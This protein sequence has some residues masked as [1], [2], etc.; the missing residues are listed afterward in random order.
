ME[1]T[2][3]IS[4][5]FAIAGALLVAPRTA[6]SYVGYV[7]APLMFIDWRLSVR[8][9]FFLGALALY[10]LLAL[11]VQVIQQ[12]LISPTSA[13]IELALLFPF[14]LFIAGVR[15][16]GDLTQAVFL[17]R[18]LNVSLVIIS[19]VRVLIFHGIPYLTTSPDQWNGLFGLGGA[20]ILTIIG[21]FGITLELLLRE[22]G[23][24]VSRLALIAAI[25]NFLVPSYMIGIAVGILA[26][27]L[28]FA[29]SFRF[30]LASSAHRSLRFFLPIA[31]IVGLAAGLPI[32][33]RL[34]SVNTT[35]TKELGV[36]P[37]VFA[38]IASFE[39]LA[40][41]QILGLGVG[42]FTSTP[43]TWLDPGLTTT[44]AHRPPELP[45]FHMSDAYSDR[46][47]DYTRSGIKNKWTFSSSLNQPVAGWAAL[48]G[49]WGLGILLIIGAFWRRLAGTL[50]SLSLRATAIFVVAVNLIDSWF[51]SPWFG[52]ALLLFYGVAE[53]ILEGGKKRGR[54]R[55]D[56]GGLFPKKGEA[57][58][59]I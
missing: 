3:K 58:E 15:P 43:Q 19:A 27:S 28:A 51:D 41:G 16:S 10:A 42:Q 47:T 59:T 23:H 34:G 50:R 24:R 20:K 52:V 11:W 26:F 37:K 32:V 54:R 55:L 48:V 12:Q 53:S 21:F 49:E 29:W 46:I 7:L 38:Q 17:L 4:L 8:Q 1:T 36:H 33:D 5:R 18:M 35:A 9:I 40:D 56:R 39:A 31:I 57:S 14:L 22:H 30:S 6:I 45:L 2:L 13:A 25:V 44:A